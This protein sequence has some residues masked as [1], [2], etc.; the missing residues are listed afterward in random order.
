MKN[1][2]TNRFFLA[3]DFF[4]S[5]TLIPSLLKS[6]HLSS[7]TNAVDVG[8]ECERGRRQWTI[9]NMENYMNK[10]MFMG[11]AILVLWAYAHIHHM[12]KKIINFIKFPFF[13]F[14][15]FLLFFLKKNN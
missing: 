8:V 4:S 7:H 5:F 10:N 1:K 13:I 11:R 6:P 2:R 15:L 12:F 14:T 3:R 9:N